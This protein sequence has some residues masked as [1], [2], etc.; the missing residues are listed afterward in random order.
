MKKTLTIFFQLLLL[1]VIFIIGAFLIMF[2]AVFDSLADH[3]V[4]T[5]VWGC[6]DED[7]SGLISELSDS[8][9]MFTFLS[10]L[11]NFTVIVVWIILKNIII[12][13]KLI[14]YLFIVTPT[15]VNNY[16]LYEILFNFELPIISFSLYYFIFNFIFLFVFKIIF[17]KNT[18]L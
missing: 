3:L 13:R 16:F 18:H 5:H 14:R 17:K 15:I 10:Y 1:F 9:R 6:H 4:M 7:C 11:I 8:L 12:Y 2:F